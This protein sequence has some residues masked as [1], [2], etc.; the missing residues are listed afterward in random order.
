[1]QSDERHP[2]TAGGGD[3]GQCQCQCCCPVPSWWLV[4]RPKLGEEEQQRRK[5]ASAGHRPPGR[6]KGQDTEIGGREREGGAKSGQEYEGGQINGEVNPRVDGRTLHAL[7]T[8]RTFWRS[9]EIIL[10]ARGVGERAWM[11]SGERRG[12]KEG[13][14]EEVRQRSRM[15]RR[16]EYRLQGK[17]D[18]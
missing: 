9:C 7:S 8:A 5:E 6:S 1:M 2:L 11:S 3:S 15:S 14:S 4:V 12:D 17:Q 16:M 13:E 18:T 10:C